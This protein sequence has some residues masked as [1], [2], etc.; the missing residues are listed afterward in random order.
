MWKLVDILVCMD[1]TL[2]EV[3]VQHQKSRT[4][5]PNCSPTV[6]RKKE[7]KNVTKKSGRA[8]QGVALQLLTC[9]CCLFESRGV[10]G[11]LTWISV[12]S[13]LCCQVQFYACSWSLLQR[14]STECGV[15]EWDREVT[16]MHRSW[17]TRGCHTTNKI[18][19]RKSIKLWQ[20]KMFDVIEDTAFSW[21]HN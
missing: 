16:T 19:V 21:W 15:S 20:R 17:L 9:R 5:Y 7:K 18:T 4:S 8:V 2:A 14:N 1:W 10:G 11:G 3:R 6:S 12:V 13:A